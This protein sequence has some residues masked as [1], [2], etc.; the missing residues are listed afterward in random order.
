MNKD[1]KLVPKKARH[2]LYKETLKLYLKSVK[3]KDEQNKIPGVN[4][5]YL[6][7]C[8]YL[9]RSKTGQKYFSDGYI[10][11]EERLPEF[12]AIKEGLTAPVNTYWWDERNYKIR[13]SVLNKM[14]ENS[15][16]KRRF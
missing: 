13:I 5:S 8:F 14:I 9:S 16:P 7:L 4:L 10:G 6:G 3:E 11:L 12:R 15:K 1:N 2:K